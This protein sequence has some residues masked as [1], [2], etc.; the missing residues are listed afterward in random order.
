MATSAA[1]VLGGLEV[2]VDALFSVQ[3][4]FGHLKLTIS[5]ILAALAKAATRADAMQREQQQTQADVKELQRRADDA[6][7][8]QVAAEKAMAA[9]AETVAGLVRREAA[10]AARV[11]ALEKELADLAALKPLLTLKLPVVVPDHASRIAALEAALQ[12]LSELNSSDKD[13][14]A[15]LE[16]RDARLAELER[17]VSETAQAAKAAE[18]AAKVADATAQGAESAAQNADAVA[19]QADTNARNAHAVAEQALALANANRGQNQAPVVA[20]APPPPAAAP[21]PAPTQ[22]NDALLRQMKQLSSALEALTARVAALEG[23]Q[24]TLQRQVQNVKAAS[25]N[26]AST[27]PPPVVRVPSKKGSSSGDDS[28]ALSDALAALQNSDAHNSRQLAACLSELAQIQAALSALE[29]AMALKAAQKD[30]ALKADQDALDQTDRRVGAQARQIND[31][32]RELAQLRDQMRAMQDANRAL[33]AKVHA[34]MEAATC[35]QCKDARP[36]VKCKKCAL[37]LCD[38]CDEALHGAPHASPAMQAHLRMPL[39]AV[40]V[41]VSPAAPAASPVH[42]DRGPGLNADNDELRRWAEEQIAALVRKEKATR[43]DVHDLASSE[44]VL[45]ARVDALSKQGAADKEAM[46]DLAAALK[47]LETELRAALAQS[48]AQGRHYTDNRVEELLL[49]LRDLER[50]L[51]KGMRS[52]LKRFERDVLVYLEG[53]GLGSGGEHGHD[54]AVGKIH[55]RCLSC[56]QTVANLQGP[57]SL[58]YT[59]AVGGGAAS[60]NVNNANV[61]PNATSMSIE[62][63]RELYLNG[64]DGAVYKGRDATSVTIAPG[65]P[66]RSAQF[67]VHYNHANLSAPTT[68]ARGTTIL[69]HKTVPAPYNAA[70][71][72]PPPSTPQRGALMRPSSAPYDPHSSRGQGSLPPTRPATR[73][74]LRSRDGGRGAGGSPQQGQIGTIDEQ[75]TPSRAEQLAAESF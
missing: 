39:G 53:H 42:S 29:K 34:L 19:R 12:R 65:D 59:R 11:A 14:R 45:R 6:E 22:N 25:A 49:K 48:A 23:Q 61:N 33:E 9:Q 63:G 60:S 37:S 70:T 57:A 38:A 10:Q 4:D 64:R 1:S 35:G 44:A 18:A 24:G 55:F 50:A 67:Q 58:L 27:A 46:A 26:A 73:S 21:L 52:E 56:D 20:A 5:A 71:G 30:L 31:L 15:A 75:K 8:K 28:S 47:R 41:D 51:E 62:R 3:V 7:Q 66:S 16:E 36:S 72:A 74:G 2:D 68:N 32:E 43:A 40:Q 17:R 69:D 54:A 13:L